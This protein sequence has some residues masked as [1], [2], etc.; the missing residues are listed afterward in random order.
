VRSTD[1]GGLFFEKVFTITVTNANET[2]TDIALSNNTA[3]ENQAVGTTIGTLS[4]TDPDAG[5]TFTYTLVA[6]TG[7]TDNASFQVVGNQLQNAVNLNFEAQSVYS[8]RIRTTDAGGLFFEKVFTIIITDANDAPTALALSP[9]SINENMPVGSTVGTFTTTDQEAQTYTYTLVA[10]AGSTD[11]ASFTISGNQLQT[12]AIF[13]F[14]VKSSYDIRVRTTDNGTPNLFFEQTFTITVNNVN[15]APTDVNLSATSIAENQTAGSVVGT[16][17]SVDQDT[18]DTFTYTL[19]AG[20]GSTDN[21]SFQI[22]GNQLQIVAPFDFETKNSYAIRIRTTDAGGLFFEKQFTITVTNVN[23]VPTD[24]ALSANT[25]NE[26]NAINAVIGTL[27]TTDPD[28]PDSFTYT[29]VAGAGSTDNASFNILGNSLRASIAFNFEAKSSYD[30]RIRTTDA[31]GLFYEEAFTITIINVNEAPTAATDALNY[32]SNTEVRVDGHAGTANA[33]AFTTTLVN[34]IDNDSDPDSIASGFGTISII[35]VTG[36]TTPNNGVYDIAADGTMRYTPPAGFTGTDPVPYQLTDGTNTVAGTINFTMTGTLRVWY[37]RNN[38][39]TVDGTVT[40]DGTSSY[41]FNTLVGAQN[42]SGVNDTIFVHVGDGG[43][44]GQNAGF[45]MKNGQ[46]LHGHGVGLT[47]DPDGAGVITPVSL[48]AASSQPQ[49]GN[50]AG[51]GVTATNFTGLEVRGLNIGA[52]GDAINL[53]VNGASTGG[54]TIDTNTIRSA[55]TEGIDISHTSTGSTTVSLHDNTIT[56][57]GNAININKTAGTLTITAF[58]DN[59]ISGNSGAGGIT[60]TGAA[61]DSN[62]G[63]AGFQTVSGG[64]T[65]IGVS[66]N[67]VGT[68]GMILTNVTGDLSF[69]DLDI[70]A[71]NGTG[72]FASAVG[73]FNAGAGTGFQLAASGNN[74]VIESVNG[75]AVDLSATAGNLLPANIVLTSINSLNSTG[76]GVSLAN[77]SGTFTV[78]GAGSAIT[79]ATGTDIAISGGSANVTYPGTITD[80]LGS[81]VT[82]A[83]ATGGTKIFSGAITDGDDGDGSGISLTSNTGAT[84]RF[85]GG[86]VLSTAANAAFTATGGG[87]VEVCDEAVC[88]GAATGSLINKITTTTGTALNV[89]NTNIGANDLEF[90]SITAG[91]AASGPATAIILNTTGAVGGLWVKGTGAAGTG[92]TIRKAGTGVSLTSTRDVSLAYL[93]MNDFTDW[94]IRGSSVVNFTLANTVI[95]GTN[96]DND[97]TDDGAIRFT[98][99]TGSAS[100]TACTISGGWEDNMAVV[101]TTGTLNRLTVTSTTFGANSTTFGNDALFVEAQNTAVMNVTVTNS[102]FTSTR[103]DHFQFNVTGTPTAD[104]VFTGNTITNNHPATVSGG[105]G[106]RIVSGAGSPTVTFTI[107]GAAGLANTMRD[108]YGAAIGV[109]KGAG[110]GTFT[111]TIDNNV[112]GVAGVVDSGSR[113]GSGISLIMAE[114]GRLD[115]AV[116][117]NDI[118]QFNNYGIFL[119]TGGTAV[120]GT[121]DLKAVVTGNLIANPG[122]TAGFPVNGI[123]LNGG[124]LPGDSFRICFTIGGAG[125]LENNFVGTGK[126]GGTDFRLRQRQSTTVY[127][128]GY[129]GANNDDAA[130]VTFVQ[131]RS[132]GTPS[133]T[134]ANTV[135]SGGGGWSTAGCPF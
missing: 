67:P 108:S 38:D 85:N 57:T 106:I 118:Y 101:N 27:S 22:V 90:R 98:E 73:N 1:A 16:L 117:N 123:H 112:I 31:G 94:A 32:L 48:I 82:V 89:A 37:V 99:L 51:S 95:N 17:S 75:A 29:L 110:G 68:S 42:A 46:K 105:G 128:N 88:N 47:F 44:T 84:I 119:Q 125:A 21:A 36:G 23:E 104:L 71:G 2:P 124:T 58:D 61:F 121:G 114:T 131:N 86:L 10:G 18:G 116:T 91:T 59:L 55:G 62:T 74:G 63:A 40:R 26:N 5:D 39:A 33:V 14:E 8:V 79:N 6:G 19:V 7:S 134:A 102:F 72:L 45:V 53:T 50:G 132:T 30:I 111:G 15:E 78:S 113:D 127:L 97:A 66:G 120:I 70:Y 77:V 81:L 11:N 20:A 41:P 107:G 52:T 76:V 135:G 87:T 130:V 96:G 100:I 65:A 13:N 122:S 103:G 43:T 109:T 4:T 64:V 24:I 80:D 25:I 49:I 93:Q 133:G 56:S 34:P 92:G 12:A 9:Q 54:I 129:A 83:N 28:S 69:T 35:P 126:N 3:P 115:V 60:I